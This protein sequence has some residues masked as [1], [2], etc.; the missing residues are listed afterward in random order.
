MHTPINP[1]ILSFRCD[2]ATLEK[3][4]KKGKMKR[5][6]ERV[7][8]RKKRV[9]EWE[10]ETERERERRALFRKPNQLLT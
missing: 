7:R 6:E 8:E 10:R 1:F 9:G 5:V 4:R 2:F 3:G